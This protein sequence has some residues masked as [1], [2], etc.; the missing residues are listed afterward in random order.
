MTGMSSR[1][2]QA[3]GARSDDPGDVPAERPAA[4]DRLDVLTGMW[5]MEARFEAG[6]F[7]PGSP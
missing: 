5:E 1:Q 4:L 7:G 6:Y 2:D 3:P